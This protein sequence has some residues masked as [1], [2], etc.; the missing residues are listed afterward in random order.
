LTTP[1]DA[2]FPATPG[3]RPSDV[4]AGALVFAGLGWSYA[5]SVV[6]LINQWNRDPNYS[7]GFFVVPIALVI[8]WTR[9]GLFDRSQVAPVWWG[10]V[11]LFVLLALRYWLYEVNEQY[12]ETAT[13]PL[14]LAS[15]ALAL[16]GWHLVRVTWPAI[17]FLFF[18]LPL[19]PSLNQELPA[20]LQAIATSGSVA[21]LQIIGL[22]VMAEG[23]VILVGQETLEVARACSGLSMLLAFVTLITA[24][25]ILVK[26][27]PVER[28]VLLVSAVPIALLSNIIRI[29]I[30]AMV[31][32]WV[33]HDWGE[34]LGHDY[35]GYLMMPIALALVGLELRLMSWLVVEVEPV[36]TS[37]YLLRGRSRARASN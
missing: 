20:R 30:T 21:L 35:A 24:V 3:V 36:G 27:P 19:P 13:A 17:A 15:L 31:Y 9:R 12:V 22:P 16:G 32:R 10:F 6:A 4:V 2:T 11:A 23:N 26:R 7:Y 8:L 34:R 28:V 5:P 29:A 14:V 25:A 33:G 18:M 37:D 1:R